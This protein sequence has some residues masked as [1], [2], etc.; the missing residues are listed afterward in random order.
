MN[1]IRIESDKIEVGSTL[2][3]KGCKIETWGNKIHK[4]IFTMHY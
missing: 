4:E 3:N 1:R 2:I